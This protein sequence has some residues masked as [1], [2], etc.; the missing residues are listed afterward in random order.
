[1]DQLRMGQAFITWKVEDGFADFEAR[2]AQAL[3]SDSDF[4]GPGSAPCRARYSSEPASPASRL[5]SR[6]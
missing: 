4:V 2:N 3:A 1:M 6:P 5:F